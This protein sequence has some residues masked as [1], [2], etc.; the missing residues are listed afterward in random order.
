MNMKRFSS[1][2]ALLSVGIAAAMTV[3]IPTALADKFVAKRNGV[4]VYE[5]AAGTSKSV[6]TLK[7]GEMVEAKE[8]SGA[9]WAVELDAGKKGFVRA[10][11][12]LKIANS[13]ANAL[14]RAVQNATA[15]KREKDDSANARARSASAVM[16]IRGLDEDSNAGARA[17]AK[18]NL[19][20]VY[21]MEDKHVPESRIDSI[22]DG[23]NTELD[24][25]E[26]KA[27]QE[28]KVPDK[29]K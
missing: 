24:S 2:V 29:K 7:K 3:F 25:K 1:S 8:R 12:I 16:G 15:S 18:P 27:Q 28:K 26:L 23:V 22:E 19:G 17:N 9:F 14:S 13:D 10:S 21:Q 6:Q 11:E 20:A 5:Q 4:L